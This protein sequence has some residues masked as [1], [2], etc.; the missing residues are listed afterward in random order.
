MSSEKQPLEW[1]KWATLTLMLI[2]LACL[3]TVG[4]TLNDIW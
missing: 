2:A 1:P 3:A 4:A